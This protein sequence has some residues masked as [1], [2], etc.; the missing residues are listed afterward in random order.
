MNTFSV[1]YNGVVQPA[2]LRRSPLAML[3]LLTVYVSPLQQV[4]FFASRL[5]HPQPMF[6]HS[7][8]S[9]AFVYKYHLLSIETPILLLVFRKLVQF[10]NYIEGN[11]T[12]T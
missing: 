11:A 2:S 1:N 10:Q 4:A 7:S 9:Q 5:R 3:S 12:I 8:I 6:R